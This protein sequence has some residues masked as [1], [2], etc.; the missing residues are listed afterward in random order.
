MIRYYE[1]EENADHSVI[2]LML[3]T[4]CDNH[5]MLC[6]NGQYDLSS[7]PVVTVE[8]L[9]NAKTVLLTGGEP[10]KIPYFADFV[11][12]LRGQ[13][14]NIENL[15]VYTSG[16]SMYHNVEQWNKNKVY[17]DIDG[18]NISPKGTNRERWAIQGML[19]KNALGIF[20]DIFASMK[21]CRLILMDR[22][23]KNYEL[24]STLNIQQFRDLGVRFD[25]EYRDWQNKFQPNGG[26]WRRLPI[27]LN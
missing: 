11:Q 15:Y 2:H 17:T 21:S 13:Y 23:E 16:Y 10:F 26:V 22:K 14:K 8:E 1:D 27:L 9:N 6:C 18:I 24:L 4:N 12:N 25:V 5:C 7:V 3:N 19:G 20:F